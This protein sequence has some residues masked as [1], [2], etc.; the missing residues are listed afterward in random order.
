MK[1]R[2]RTL[3]LSEYV[4]KIVDRKEVILFLAFYFVSC[5][6]YYT[7][8]WISWGGLEPGGSLYFNIEEFF[9]AAGTD[10]II[11]FLVTIPIWYTTIILLK[12]S[13]HQLILAM[14]VLFL[15]LYLLTCYYGQYAIKHFFG[16][17]MF[18]GGQKVIWSFY[19]LM[20]FYLVQFAIIHAYTYFKRYKKEEKNNIKLY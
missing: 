19:N 16:W 13:S 9:A 4:C 1:K 5:V 17:A 2:S 20:L 11:S 18:W 7:A 3:T 6:I 12:K 8:T 15:P 14:H 10:F